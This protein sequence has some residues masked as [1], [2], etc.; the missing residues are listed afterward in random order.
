MASSLN[1]PEDGDLHKGRK[2]TSDVSVK[3]GFD[4]IL[5]NPITVT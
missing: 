4:Y 5:K 2:E 3:T 1:A